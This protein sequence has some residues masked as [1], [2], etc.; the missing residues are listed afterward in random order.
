MKKLLIWLVL[1][2]VAIGGLGA[3]YIESLRASRPP[4]PPTGSA[5]TLPWGAMQIDRDQDE[6]ESDLEKSFAKSID[7]ESSAEFDADQNGVRDYSVLVLSGG[8]A[9]GA[10]GAGFL[11]GWSEHGDR[12]NFKIVTGVSTGS[13][14]ATFAFLGSEYD[15]TLTQVFT[16]NGTDNI[17]TERSILGALLGDSAWDS[18]PLEELIEE[19]ITLDLVDAVAERHARGYRL[20]VGTSN[21]D[22]GEFIIWDMGAIA[23]SDRADRLEHYRRILLASCSI[24]VLFPPVYFPVEIEGGK[25]WE[26]HMDGGA[27]AQLFLRGFMLDFEDTLKKVGANSDINVSMY[28]IRNGTFGKQTERDIVSAS[29]VSIAAA[30]I[31]GVFDL[32]TQS[33]LFRVYM[34]T[35]RFNIGFNMAAIPD[36]KFPDLDPVDFNLDLMRQIYDYAFEAASNGYEWLTVPPGLD[37]DEWFEPAISN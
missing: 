31:N 6:I 17:Y 25:Y 18:E 16:Q 22:T 2:V 34:L 26:M 30:T 33:S 15:D 37:P 11:S 27:Q 4:V 29:S 7:D 24:P 20:F 14:Q 9:A 12:P 21:M 5:I 1:S 13:L 3:V 36:D 10:F 23:S 35:S 8:G 32:S 19:Y 28:I